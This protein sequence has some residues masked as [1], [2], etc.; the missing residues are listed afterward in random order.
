MLTPLYRSELSYA[1][2]HLDF[3][4]KETLSTF[5]NAQVSVNKLVDPLKAK[6]LEGD[7]TDVYN[8]YGTEI[9]ATIVNSS[10]YWNQK[11][12]ETYAM[13]DKLGKPD[14]L[15]TLSDNPHD[16]R[17]GATV[18]HGSFAAW[19]PEEMEEISA[20]L[21]KAYRDRYTES[22]EQIDCDGPVDEDDIEP[23]HDQNFRRNPHRYQDK[24]FGDQMSP[25]LH[26]CFA[27]TWHDGPVA[28]NNSYEVV[29]AFF[30]KL[31]LF[32]R[33][34]LLKPGMYSRRKTRLQHVLCFH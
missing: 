25:R 23:F 26:K 13:T 14:L 20:E 12:S 2:Y 34:F 11:C 24:M 31:D 21:D 9:P 10:K 4:I 15:V 6:D 29:T 33:E 8:R 30:Q 28:V 32:K 27:K 7:N 3:L 22:G 17:L 1:F 18:D 16:P 5:N 19:E